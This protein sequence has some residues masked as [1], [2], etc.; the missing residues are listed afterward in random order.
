MD[1]E[2]KVELSATVPILEPRLLEVVAADN[3]EKA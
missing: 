1:E 2:Y 3:W